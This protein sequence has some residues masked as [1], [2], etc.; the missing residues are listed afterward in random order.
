MA[1]RYKNGI[2]P[3]ELFQRPH[4]ASL[5]G[6]AQYLRGGSLQT[7]VG[8]RDHQLNASEAASRKRAQEL[9]PEGL[10]FR[11]TD[12]HAEHLTTPLGI[13]CHSYYYGDRYDPAGLAHF[14]VGGVDP[15][16]RPLTF[17]GSFEE[18]VHAF[19]DVGAKS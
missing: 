8:I 18:S 7:F 17:D 2:R 5:P 9:R 13:N 1:N 6:R 4:A 19:V 11:R 12:G 3:D 10:G 15:Q 16:I 14:D